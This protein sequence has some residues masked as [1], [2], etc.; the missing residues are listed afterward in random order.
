[1]VEDGPADEAG[2]PGLIEDEPAV[3]ESDVAG[4]AVAGAERGPRSSVANAD[5]PN[6]ANNTTHAMA[7]LTRAPLLRIAHRRQ[8]PSLK[9]EVKV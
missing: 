8:G 4:E 9:D 2:A 1:V 7:N 5:A 3:V 6:D